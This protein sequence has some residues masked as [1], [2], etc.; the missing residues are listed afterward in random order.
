V[1]KKFLSIRR[2]GVAVLTGVTLLGTVSVLGTS[3]ASAATPIVTATG[4]TATNVLSQEATVSQP[5]ADLTLTLNQTAVAGDKVVLNIPCS[6]KMQF[7]AVAPTETTLLGSGDS[8]I[9]VS[10]DNCTSRNELTLTV[11]GTPGSTSVIHNIAVITQ[12]TSTGGQTP[13]PIALTGTYLPASG[14]NTTFTTPSLATVSQFLVQSDAPQVNLAAGAA[15][16]SISNITITEPYAGAIP[17]PS[18]PTAGQG[19]FVCLL[20]SAGTWGT[21]LPTLGITG[22][23]VGTGNTGTG[24]ANT[25]TTS[26]TFQPFLTTPTTSATSFTL[27]GLTV[28]APS[29][30]QQVTIKVTMGNTSSCTDLLFRT[31]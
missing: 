28:N 31:L 11:A 23:G 4:G 2:W 19:D 15:A 30:A 16:A 9:V 12:G 7:S 1:R 17:N 21:T 10:A 29:I 22:T 20:L 8:A 5:L 3:V 14:S 27:S 25:T 6:T 13:G 18:F 26:L 24:P